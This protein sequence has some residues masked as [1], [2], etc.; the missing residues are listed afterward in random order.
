MAPGRAEARFPLTESHRC[1]KT[2]KPTW[3]LLRQD[4][5]KA[6]VQLAETSLGGHALEAGQHVGSVV[7]VRDESD[8][9][10]LRRSEENVGKELGDAA[11][12]SG[13]GCQ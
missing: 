4:W 3:D 6:S 9:N 2:K 8:P 10:R 7:S 12:C 1:T 5:N 13:G 11:A